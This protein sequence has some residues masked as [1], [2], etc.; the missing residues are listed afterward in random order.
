[1]CALDSKNER[2]PSRSSAAVRIRRSYRGS[3]DAGDALLAEPVGHERARRGAEIGEDGV[4]HAVDRPT[5]ACGTASRIRSAASAFARRCSGGSVASRNSVGIPVAATPARRRSHVPHEPAPRGRERS[6]EAS[7]SIRRR[8]TSNP[9]AR[10][11]RPGLVETV[12]GEERHELVPGVRHRIGLE[13][14]DQ[15]LDRRVRPRVGHVGVVAVPAV[16]EHERATSPAGGGRGD[17]DRAAPGVAGEHDGPRQLERSTTVPEQSGEVVDV[18]VVGVER[19]RAAEAGGVDANVEDPASTSGGTRRRGTIRCRRARARAR[20]TKG[21]RPACRTADAHRCPG[22]G[23]RCAS[24]HARVLGG[25][26]AR[27]AAPAPDRASARASGVATDRA[28]AAASGRG[29]A[30]GRSVSIGVRPALRRSSCRSA[31]RWRAASCAAVFASPKSFDLRNWENPCAIPAAK[32][33]DLLDRRRDRGR[34]RAHGGVGAVGHRDGAVG[35]GVEPCR[36]GS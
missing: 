35:D 33:G 32:P 10:R 4:P 31:S 8:P 26:A 12:L 17:R 36:A 16:E 20:T 29:C 25:P 28:S 27:P 11:E 6:F 24:G 19:A 2:K 21:R 3:G 14:G 1:M 15:L 5:S 9:P 7:A 18:V 13:L 34:D 30:A 22:D 23:R